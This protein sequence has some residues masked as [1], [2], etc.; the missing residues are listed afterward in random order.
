M[1]RYGQCG[2][3]GKK[4]LNHQIFITA[5]LQIVERKYL[6]AALGSTGAPVT[7]KLH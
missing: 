6:L 5:H 4:A 2:S 1:G 3:C 7:K